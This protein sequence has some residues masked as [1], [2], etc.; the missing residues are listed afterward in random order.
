MAYREPGVYLE[1]DYRRPPSPVMPPLVPLIIGEGRAYVDF[2]D[3][4]IVRDD[5]VA[6]DEL[7]STKVTA[8]IS[9]TDENGDEFIQ[10]TDYQLDGDNEVEWLTGEGIDN[11]DPGETY[12][13]TYKARPEESDYGLRLITEDQLSDYYGGMF[14]ETDE[15]NGGSLEI[16]SKINPVYLGAYICFNSGASHVGVLQVEPS[17]TQESPANPYAVVEP[18][19]FQNALNEHAQYSESVYRIVPM[20]TDSE[21]IGAVVP[22]L[23]Q[24][25][26]VEERKERVAVVGYDHSFTD[27]AD[28]IDGI[29]AF[30]EGLENKRVQVIGGDGGTM[31]LSDGN[32]HNLGAEYLCAAVA[33]RYA[34]NSIQTSLTRDRITV[35]RELDTFKLNNTQKNSMASS[36]VTVLQQPGGEGTAIVIRHSL[37]TDMS[38]VQSRE[39]SVIQIGDYTSKYYREALDPYI[40]RYNINADLLQRVEN[41]V[42]AASET[43]SDDRVI[44]SAEILNFY[45]DEDNPDSII[46]QIRIYVPYPCNY[47]DISLLIY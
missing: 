27:V 42:N 26:S 17:G 41:A 39:P 5:E 40:G 16:V 24:M 34:L 30:S 3:T 13:V 6:K 28:Y 33:G 36:G 18:T 11:P 45:Q 37:T 22:H 23:E 25:S 44:N 47:I 7:P 21:V 2:D 10:D 19:D 14:M 29:K 9:I 46:L 12:Y 43:L 38:S 32:L 8:I 31:T 1:R 35:F 15:V 20:S 4:P